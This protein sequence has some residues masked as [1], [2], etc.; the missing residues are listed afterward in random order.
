M[1]WEVR[2]GLCPNGMG[3]H[4]PLVPPVGDQLDH[5]IAAALKTRGLTTITLNVGRCSGLVERPRL[6]PLRMIL[7]T[8]LHPFLEMRGFWLPFAVQ[9]AHTEYEA[10]VRRRQQVSG[11]YG[12]LKQAYDTFLSN[13]KALADAKLYAHGDIWETS[14]FAPRLPPFEIE[15]AV[16][17][18][19]ENFLFS[20]YDD[21]T[22]LG[23]ALKRL[24]ELA[25]AD[26]DFELHGNQATVAT[27]FV[28][29]LALAYRR[30]TGKHPASETAKFHD[31][32]RTAYDAID[33]L[34]AIKGLRRHD[35][36]KVE[37]GYRNVLDPA[38]D[39]RPRYFTLHWL[40]S[41]ARSTWETIVQSG[42][43]K[44]E[45]AELLC[46]VIH[47]EDL[48]PMRRRRRLDQVFAQ[49]AATMNYD[50]DV[51]NP[52]VGSY[53]RLNTFAWHLFNLPD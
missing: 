31:F 23:A 47:E 14:P 4:G 11:G 42:G 45:I 5:T 3:S 27:G 53:I 52:E 40:I 35:I 39:M 49:A 19:V 9:Y 20:E 7:G 8:G 34:P 24:K 32:L 38:S 17:D 10:Q 22:A 51:E 30:L 46:S 29:I 44:P 15:L 26:E 1:F 43:F 25:L 2:K 16:E 6:Q 28:A 50:F 13:V 21:R 12:L 41:R 36:S 48:L 18:V 37:A 33:Q